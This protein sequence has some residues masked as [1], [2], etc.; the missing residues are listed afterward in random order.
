MIGFELV[1][2][3]LSTLGGIDR[4][5]TSINV[6]RV[7]DDERDEIDLFFGGFDTSSQQNKRWLMKDLKVGDEFVI[8]VVDISNQSTPDKIENVNQGDLLIDGKLR[9]YLALKKYLELAGV[10]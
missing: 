1:I 2:N 5:V 10:I 6:N 4:G 7:K 8:K 3:G 9:A